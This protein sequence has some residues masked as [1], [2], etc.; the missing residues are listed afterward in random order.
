MDEM[1]FDMGGAA[2]VLGTFAALADLQPAINVVGLIPAA[3]TC[4][5][6][7]P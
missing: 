5:M 2:S 3:K 6:A 4:P 1:K 7:V